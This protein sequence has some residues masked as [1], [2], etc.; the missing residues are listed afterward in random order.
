MFS[1]VINKVQNT[2]QMSQKEN[3]FSFHLC[4][5]FSLNYVLNV[6]TLP[7]DF[8]ICAFSVNTAAS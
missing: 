2:T 3:T 5:R 4:P 8:F 7:Q 1:C 6:N